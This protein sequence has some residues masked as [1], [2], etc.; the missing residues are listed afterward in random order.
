MATFV[1][2]ILAAFLAASAQR[3]HNHH[4]WGPVLKTTALYK[5]PLSPVPL[6]RFLRRL[7]EKQNQTLLSAV[8]LKATPQ[9]GLPF[10][11]AVLGLEN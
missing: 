5:W 1:C 9:Y 10:S 4:L 11:I 7:R 6:E 8:L 3:R 2:A